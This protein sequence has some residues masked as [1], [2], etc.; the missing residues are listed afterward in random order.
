MIDLLIE[1][2][3]DKWGKDY[4]L[5]LESIEECHFGKDQDEDEGDE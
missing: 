2:K 3:T 5:W 1:T 4:E